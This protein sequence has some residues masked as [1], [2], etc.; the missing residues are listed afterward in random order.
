MRFQ[1]AELATLIILVTALLAV[2]VLYFLNGV[3]G[4]YTA[5]SGDG[6]RVAVTGPILSGTT[7]HT[8]GHII[9]SIKTDLGPINVFVP[10]SSEAFATAKNAVPGDEITV[11][12]KVQI[13][14]N[15][16]EIVADTIQE[17]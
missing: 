17:K 12:G 13:Y 2:G 16:K 14:N 8:G 4:P 11:T 3:A 9:L 6:D 10:A 1:K 5:S 15:E 7:T